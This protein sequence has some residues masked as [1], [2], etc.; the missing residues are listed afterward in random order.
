MTEDR[1]PE[2]YSNFSTDYDVCGHCHA[3]RSETCRRTNVSRVTLAT[4][5]IYRDG[6]CL[7][8]W[9]DYGNYSCDICRVSFEEIYPQYCKTWEI[10]KC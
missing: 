6:D 5:P 10:F 1:F 7:S 2:I 3:S 8:S 4:F 9:R